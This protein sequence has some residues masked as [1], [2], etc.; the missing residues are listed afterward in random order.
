MRVC[1]TFIGC[2]FISVVTICTINFVFSLVKRYS[3]NMFITIIIILYYHLHASICQWCNVIIIISLN[4]CSA[5]KA[6]K[7]N[8]VRGCCLLCIVMELLILYTI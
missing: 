6:H 2:V 8:R 3:F 1:Y 7:L 5:E 4:K